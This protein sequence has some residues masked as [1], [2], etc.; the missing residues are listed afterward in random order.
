MAAYKALY[1][2]PEYTIH[3]KFSGVL[4]VTYITCMYGV[5][6]PMLFPLAAINFFN[7]WVCER[8]IVAY[9]VRL[10]PALDDGLTKNFITRLKWAPFLLIVN[11]WWMVGNK[12]IFNNEMNQFDR[13]YDSMRSGHLVN[14]DVDWAFPMNYMI[15]GAV[16]IIGAKIVFK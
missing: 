14:L 9:Q 8:L 1:S 7:Q 12:S 10:P 15:I 6:M 2:G 16:V 13:S 5:G 4:N 3:F 11:G